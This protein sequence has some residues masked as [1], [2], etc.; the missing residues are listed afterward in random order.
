[1]FNVASPRQGRP[2]KTKI[3]I[4]A[5]NERQVLDPSVLDVGLPVTGK[6][7]RVTKAVGNVD[8]RGEGDG[9][10]RNRRDLLDFGGGAVKPREPGA[11]R[12]RCGRKRIS[13]KVV[14]V[15]DGRVVLLPDDAPVRG[16]PNLSATLWIALPVSAG[17]LVQQDDLTGQEPGRVRDCARVAASARIAG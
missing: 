1:A 13:G 10:P 17:G 7:C 2:L 11:S 12:L 16:G 3:A 9:R 6:L 15:G 14:H 8:G 4:V 5:A